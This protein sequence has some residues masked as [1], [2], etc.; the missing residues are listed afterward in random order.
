MSFGF[1]LQDET[2]QRT[3]THRQLYNSYKLYYTIYTIVLILKG[4]RSA[5]LQSLLVWTG[6][7]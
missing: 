4:S 6:L 5:D 3:L 2:D 7:F 1:A